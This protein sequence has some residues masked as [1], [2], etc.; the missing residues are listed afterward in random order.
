MVL[1]VVVMPAAATP[2]GLPAMVWLLAT[3]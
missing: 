2:K 1:V 3:E